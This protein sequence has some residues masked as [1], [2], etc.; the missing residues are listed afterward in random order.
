MTINFRAAKL[1]D[2]AAIMAIEQQGFSPAEA[3]TQASM[4]ERI[5]QYPETFIVATEADQVLGYIVGPTSMQR[6][7]ADILF[8]QA[9]PN[10]AAD[11]YQTVL[12][13]AVDPQQRQRGIAS[14][15]LTQLRLAAHQNHRQ[16]ITLTCLARLV[17]F[18][19]KNGYQNEGLSTSQHANE[20][21]YNLVLPL[22]PN[23]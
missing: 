3:A 4:R 2:L 7:I 6:Y 13:L 15:L 19:E 18:Y 9:L 22:A 1:T 14:E 12:S 17:P 21:W 23:A 8:E 10:Q 20:A 16:A 11:H 5:L